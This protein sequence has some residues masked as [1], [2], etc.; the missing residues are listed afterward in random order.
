MT[1]LLTKIP[2]YYIM[3]INIV[4]ITYINIAKKLV[5]IVLEKSASLDYNNLVMSI[6]LKKVEND[7]KFYFK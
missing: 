2:M 7:R 4:Y 3:Y 5:N 1:N 6:N